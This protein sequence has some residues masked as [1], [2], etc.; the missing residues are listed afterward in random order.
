MIATSI[1]SPHRVRI[2][3]VGFHGLRD[4]LEEAVP[5]YADVAEVIVLDKIYDDAVQGIAVLRT[6]TTL[7][8]VVAAGSNGHYLREHL[9]IPV[10]LIKPDGFDLFQGLA[11]AATR[12]RRVALVTYGDIPAEVAAF[13]ERY[14]LGVEL[15]AYQ[16]E[17][18]AES[19]VRDLAA[20]GVESIVA[21]G[22]VVDLARE[23]NM[24]G[25][26]LYSQVAVREAMT[27]A[28]DIA[29]VARQEI[30]R[31]QSSIRYWR[32]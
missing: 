5:V 11:R 23:Y 30:A 9:D 18:E 13:N 24:D 17:A 12:S 31:R 7:D 20:D 26:L 21:P 4:L 29:R 16:N 14:G 10:V 32:S 3:A 27:A 22:L 15:R 6:S 8:V 19:L 2:V 28:I 1:R 25:L